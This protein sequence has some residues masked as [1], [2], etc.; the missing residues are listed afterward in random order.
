MVAV[1]VGPRAGGI[2]AGRAFGAKSGPCF[3]PGH[4]GPSPSRSRLRRPGIST[5]R[6]GSGGPGE[7]G[8]SRFQTAFRYKREPLETST[9]ARNRDDQKRSHLRVNERLGHCALCLV[10]GLWGYSSLETKRGVRSSKIRS[11]VHGST[12]EATKTIIKTQ[13]RR[14]QSRRRCGPGCDQSAGVGRM[15]G[16]DPSRAGVSP[17]ALPCRTR[18]P[19]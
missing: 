12:P 15:T 17:P 7:V 18:S 1:G 8:L 6:V 19:P 14:T 4:H 9:Q 11:R 2:W 16:G 5:I 3:I 10:S 13:R